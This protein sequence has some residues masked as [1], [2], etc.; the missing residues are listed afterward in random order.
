MI[1]FTFCDFN[2][3]E[4]KH[5]LCNLLNHY[6]SDPMG[7]YPP[8]NK[9]EQSRLLN[10]LKNHPTVEVLFVIHDDRYV[11]MAT[12]FT[13]YSTF[14]LKPYLYIH[15]V[16][17]LNESRG[18]GLGKKLVNKLIEISA[19]RGFCKLTLEVRED[20]VR[21]KSLYSKLGFQESEPLMHFW[22]KKL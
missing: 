2:N 22:T 3:P 5:A 12:T 8:L 6:M 10:D 17:V 13:N 20:N 1:H 7:N 18:R 4:H 21:A 16:V 15:D 9:E 11:G 19:Q 14:N